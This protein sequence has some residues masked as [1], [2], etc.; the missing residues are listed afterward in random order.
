MLPFDNT[1]HVHQAGT[2]RS[3]NI[4]GSGGHVVFHLITPHAD[5]DC[6][7]FHGK[8]SAKAATL[9]NM[10]GFENFDSFNQIEQITQFIVI[11]NIHLGG[12]G[13]K[14][15]AHPMTAIMDADLMRKACR[16]LGRF[17]YIVNKFTNITNLSRSLTNMSFFL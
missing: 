15:F 3:D 1:L 4:F 14:Q 9:V 6:L 10:A 13:N 16:N 11:R 12:S 2:V 17:Q 8:H 5:G 7:L